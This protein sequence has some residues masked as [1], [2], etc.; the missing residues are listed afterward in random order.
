RDALRRSGDELARQAQGV[1]AA[2]R[3]LAGQEL[4]DARAELEQRLATVVGQL[5]R[6]HGLVRELE[7][8][9]GAKFAELAERLRAADASADERAGTTRQLA[10][11]LASSAARGRWGERLAED[12][13]RLSGLV[14]GLHYR[15]QTVLAGS[16]R[17]PDFTFLLPDGLLLHLDVKFPF[18]NYLRAD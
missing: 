6:L 16:G 9:R 8:D 14:E 13:L 10:A 4:Q 17:R 5:E 15:R 11:V 7:R 1:V 2:E 3:R 18:E 12:V